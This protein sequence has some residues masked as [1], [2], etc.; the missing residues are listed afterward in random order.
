MKTALKLIFSCTLGAICLVGLSIMNAEPADAK[1]AMPNC[2][3]LKLEP[4]L[5]DVLIGS[6]QMPCGASCDFFRQPT[7]VIFYDSA[8]MLP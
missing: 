4:S 5:G 7:G 1:A 6:C 8:C 2:P 3:S